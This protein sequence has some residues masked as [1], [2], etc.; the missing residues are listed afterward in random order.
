M[1]LTVTDRRNGLAITKKKSTRKKTNTERSGTDDDEESSVRQ[2]DE[3]DLSKSEIL[4]LEIYDTLYIHTTHTEKRNNINDSSDRNIQTIARVESSDTINRSLQHKK[5]NIVQLNALRVVVNDRSELTSVREEDNDEKKT[6]DSDPQW[7]RIH[8]SPNEI[9]TNRQVNDRETKI[10]HVS[11]TCNEVIVVPILDYFG[12]GQARLISM[13]KHSRNNNVR[14]GEEDLKQ[15]VLT[16]N[17]E[18]GEDSRQEISTFTNKNKYPLD[19]NAVELKFRKRP[20][21]SI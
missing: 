13:Q 7:W 8:T 16:F 6:S 19:D 10:K 2:L 9:N 17:S 4:T 14:K 18:S 21:E 15:E 5:D 11:E 1:T 20:E 12:V 3:K